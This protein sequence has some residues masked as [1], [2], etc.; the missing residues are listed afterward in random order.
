MKK[1]V[2]SVCIFILSLNIMVSANVNSELNDIALLLKN[3]TIENY[4]SILIPLKGDPEGFNILKS[5]D[6]TT[7]SFG[8]GIK[9][10][11]VD[12][13]KLKSAYNKGEKNVLPYLIEDNKY[14]F[15]II[16]SDREVATAEI[17]KTDSGYKVLCVSSENFSKEREN[18]DFKNVKYI[19][20]T[21]IINGFL[22]NDGN[23]ETFIDLDKNESVSEISTKDISTYNDSVMDDFIKRAESSQNGLIGG[24]S[25]FED[26]NNTVILPILV[27]AL[28]CLSLLG[29]K[30]LKSK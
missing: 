12:F 9:G 25:S 23:K 2:L 14:Y 15:P 4:E 27:I 29:V 8:E 7:I 28:M 24:G 16:V 10:Y 22:I 11:K 13:K 21:T 26:S 20:Q 5:D 19:K 17:V 6:L 18:I 30:K 3:G 1:I